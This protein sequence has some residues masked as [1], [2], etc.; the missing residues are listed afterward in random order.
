MR[1]IKVPLT[2]AD[3]ERLA[4]IA[5]ARN[6]APTLPALVIDAVNSRYN[7]VLDPPIPPPK[8]VGNP[9]GNKG[10]PIKQR[11]KPKGETK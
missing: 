4:S 8:R 2:E 10:R 5:A 7:L 9:T 3:Y 11:R 6:P 1:Y